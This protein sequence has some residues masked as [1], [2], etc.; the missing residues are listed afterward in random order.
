MA[1]IDLSALRR[2]EAAERELHLLREKEHLR[3]ELPARF[4]QELR[5]PLNAING[6]SELLLDS[7][8]PLEGAEQRQMV[9]HI[10]DAG[11]QLLRQVEQVLKLPR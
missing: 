9:R 4:S 1:L 5:T 3:S 7:S 8:A 11:Q 10:L 6:F 2:S